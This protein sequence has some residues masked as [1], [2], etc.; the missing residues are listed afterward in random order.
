ME[1]TTLL[2]SART[3]APDH[4]IDW[5]DRIA[6]HGADAIA[7]VQPWLVDQSLAAFAV[8]V[9][10]LAGV[11]GEAPLAAKVL[12][13]ARTRVPP[14]VSGDVDWALERLKA[15]QRPTSTATPKAAAPVRPVRREALRA[16]V[17]PRRPS[18]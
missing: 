13:A 16:G 18:R 3:A 14:T 11:N 5:R 7:G 8:R 17:A 9:I 2:E 6:A 1:L 15:S 4:R 10:E 12:R